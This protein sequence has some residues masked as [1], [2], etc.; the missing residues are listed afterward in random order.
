MRKGLSVAI[1]KSLLFTFLFVLS[2]CGGSST[3]EPVSV[4]PPVVVEPTTP[5]P[6]PEPEPLTGIVLDAEVDGLMYQTSS[7]LSGVTNAE[8]HFRYHAADTV[9]FSLAGIDFPEFN[10]GAVITPLDLVNTT[11]FNDAALV[12]LLRLLQSLDD[13]RDA[14]QGIRLSPE[15]LTLLQQAGISYQDLALPLAE[16]EQLLV[17]NNVFAASGAD[18]MLTADAA[19]AHF[20][21][22][23]GN[24]DVIDTDGDG[25]ANV[26]DDDDDNDG[27]ADIFDAFPWDATEQSDFD[28]DLIGDNADND[29]DNDGIADSNDTNLK[30]IVELNTGAASV[31]HQLLH[32]QRNRLF[33]TDKSAKQLSVI[34]TVTGE[35]IDVLTFDKMPWRMTFS[36]DNTTLYVAL[37]NREFQYYEYE[38]QEGGSIVAI[39]VASL[40]I[41]NRIDVEVDPFDLV[42]T[43]NGKLIVSSGSNQWTQIHAYNLKNGEF[44]GSAQ[45]YQQSYLSLHPSQNWV[46]AADTGIS[47]S[48]FEK[49]DISGT[50]IVAVGDSPY[51]GNYAISG[52]VWT[53][54]DGKYVFSRGGH[55]FLAG[56]MTYVKS[57]TSGES[58]RD[59]SFDYSG[60]TAFVLSGQADT[61]QLVNLQSLEVFSSVTL[62]GEIQQMSVG[63]TAAWYV[64]AVN[65]ELTLVKTL[66]PCSQCENNTAPKADFS[67]APGAGTTL[68]NYLFDAAISMDA[69]DGAALMFRW[70]I[71]NDGVWDTDFSTTA[72]LSHRFFI[73][74]THYVKVQVR[75]KSGLTAIKLRDIN[76]LQGIDPGVTLTDSTPYSLGFG[77]T[78]VVN[79]SQRQLAYIS[80]KAAKRL[81]VLDLLTGLTVKYFDFSFMPE[82]MTMSPDGQFL[83]V[84]LLVREHSYYWWE[85]GQ[86]GYI[87]VI[88]L[89]NQTL[90]NA[91]SIPTDPYD[92]VVNAA[93][94]LIVSS[95]SGQWT[96]IYAFNAADGS[97]L[98][99]TGIRQQSRLSLHPSGNWVFAANT[100]TSPSDFEKFD[101]SGNGIIAAGD[102]PY[103]GDHRVSGNIWTSPDGQY[104]ISK[105]G[106][107]FRSDDMTFVMNLTAQNESVT[108][109]QFDEEQ[110]L[111]FVLTSDNKLKYFNL[112]S[113]QLVGQQDAGNAQWL[114]LTDDGLLL[115]ADAQQP[116]AVTRISHPCPLCGSNTAPMA[117]F[118]Y[119]DN[120]G[121]TAD[122]FV[123][124]ASVSTDAEDDAA[125]QFRWD[126]DGDGNWDTGFSSNIEFS[127]KF[128]LAGSYNV[129]LQVKDS[130]GL[131]HVLTQEI[132]V[133][134]GI[135][136][137]IEVI[138]ND[139]AQLALEAT[140]VVTDTVRNQAYMTDMQ[141]QRLYVINLAD[142]S[143][144]R[145]FELEFLPE[146]LTMSADGSRLYVALLAEQHSDYWWQG[147]KDGYIAVFDLEQQALINAY[148][149]SVDPFDLAVS[150]AGDLIVSS[151]S[152]AEDLIVL[153]NSDDGSVISSIAANSKAMFALHADGTTLYTTGGYYNSG[154]VYQ[155]SVGNDSITLQNQSAYYY[156]YAEYAG[157]WL[158][159]DGNSVILSGSQ[160]LQADNLAL[161]LRL[162]DSIDVIH[163][164]VSDTLNNY[165]YILSYGT[166]YRFNADTYELLAQTDAF[167]ANN[168]VFADGKLYAVRNDT[169]NVVF[170]EVN[171]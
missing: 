53:S 24:T 91:F 124:D 52:R 67:Y 116:A 62:F 94:K 123:F 139:P 7:G 60:T 149:I 119:F 65:N 9:S 35:L 115:I 97:L 114:L 128:F 121:T 22:T 93:G 81:Y 38:E 135:D 109:L 107:L 43:A 19:I 85:S 74:G 3:E 112:T 167:S 6:E 31:T 157:L 32:G 41:V 48:D 42:V 132:E 36:A 20:S 162:S 46:F 142:G 70:D 64:L 161:V 51:H 127:H 59:I 28:G 140:A 170:A 98:G 58:I 79:D 16:F 147:D 27:T 21:E 82:R 39:D 160:L 72:T 150:A 113:W 171:F 11:L 57:L 138:D 122:T 90:V 120:G 156:N 106:D 66:H 126:V 63:K 80:D 44:L 117:D 118:T 169:G 26:R 33:R 18:A 29:D 105:G 8:G 155:Y 87:A 45:T 108:Q 13:D 55:V 86:E 99:S 163:D 141:R 5:E 134:Q 40:K 95:G 153:L 73:A 4:T 137:G 165:L 168:L 14:A 130:G 102:S 166:V 125:L 47:P 103:H 10:A 101:I 143:T 2:G 77:R 76:V 89:A 104:L 75:D 50:G 144:E 69:E 84:A 17:N 83:Y 111:L 23:L 154:I 152:G 146:R 158:T 96:S 88:D 159:A 110:N 54:P 25:I 151:G 34:N 1:S 131:T 164:T 12:N 92:L 30:L 61:V 37:L 136:Y 129:K 78:H 68:D 56:D 133:V 148:A 49:F 100:D 145:Y 71:D 15:K